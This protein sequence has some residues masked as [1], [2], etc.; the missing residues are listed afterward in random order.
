MTQYGSTLINRSFGR[1]C[2]LLLPPVIDLPHHA[3]ATVP[4]SVRDVLVS[5]IYPVGHRC[6]AH[7]LQGES[8]KLDPILLGLLAR[9]L[10]Q[11]AQVRV[12]AAGRIG[13]AVAVAKNEHTSGALQAERLVDDGAQIGGPLDH[14]ELRCL[15]L[16]SLPDWDLDV[17]LPDG[18]AHDV[19]HLILAADCQICSAQA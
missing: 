12:P 1:S 15:P 14:L 16:L 9:V 10:H 4:S 2:R 17:L 8:G 5:R 13:L 18:L 3:I 19:P 11:P 7:V 6:Q